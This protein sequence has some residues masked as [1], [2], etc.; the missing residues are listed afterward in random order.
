[1]LYAQYCF[2][3]GQ[4]LEGR[5]HANVAATLAIASGLHRIGD[6]NFA[7]LRHGSLATLTVV[8]ALDPPHDWVEYSDRVRLCWSVLMLDSL[9]NVALG[10]PPSLV[11]NATMGAQFNLPWPLDSSKYEH[12]SS[13]EGRTLNDTRTTFIRADWTRLSRRKRLPRISHR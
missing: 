10:H 5:Y 1:M 13:V 4:V 11:G 3:T 12:V 9:W 6:M 2:V 7:E 8:H